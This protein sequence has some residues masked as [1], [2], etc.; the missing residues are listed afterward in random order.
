M[1]GTKSIRRPGAIVLHVS[2]QA[3]EALVPRKRFAPGASPYRLVRFSHDLDIGSALAAFLAVRLKSHGVSKRP[4]VLA[5]AP[6]LVTSKII[7]LPRLGARELEGVVGRRAAALLELG[8]AETAF[9]GIALDGEDA[10]ERRW[11]VHG[12]AKKPLTEF[13]AELRSLGFPV[14]HAI[15]ARTA[16]FLSARCMEAAVSNGATLVALFEREHCAIGLL[17]E[18][19]LVHLSVLQGG[20]H[21]H[22]TEPQTAKA[23][24]QELRGID[25]FWR[26]ASRGDRVAAVAIGGVEPFVVER[27][28]TAILSALGEVA[29]TTLDEGT[30]DP[31]QGDGTLSVAGLDGL[32]EEQGEGVAPLDHAGEKARIALLTS[33]ANHRVSSLDFAVDLRPR[34]RDILLVGGASALLFGTLAVGLRDDFRSR[35]ASLATETQV[36]QAASADLDDLR[37][38][39]RTVQTLEGQVRS[40]CSELESVSAIGLPA[41]DLLNGVF[42]AFTDQTALL[43]I[44]AA[45]SSVSTGGAGVLRLRGV[46]EDLP[47][48]TASALSR[49]E[50]N[51][52]AVQ[53]VSDVQIEMPSLSDRAGDL[54]G[55]GRTSL[56]FSA[57]L[58]LGA[59]AAPPAEGNQRGGF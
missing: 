58:Q 41:R 49:L 52:R 25:A 32:E 4:V 21:A 47:G 27:L 7:E 36:V 42:G 10:V 57:V 34:A 24:V 50:S 1:V 43:S 26:R 14:K 12:T 19:R 16:P 38:L 20:T 33:L 44:S 31:R 22:L 35:A 18:G 37:T 23:F 45:G 9:S 17:A 13:Q 28:N 53:G 59:L 54:R 11:L 5:L 30:N 56:R 6:D 46:V 48:E 40:A 8:A 3:I 2:A 51:L 39:E 55:G 29:V 15:P